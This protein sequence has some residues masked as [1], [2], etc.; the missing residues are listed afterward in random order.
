[1]ATAVER[2]LAQI[3]KA[4]GLRKS[5]PL[6][7]SGERDQ[8]LIKGVV[9]PDINHGGWSFIGQPPSPTFREKSYD[10]L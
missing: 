7:F 10:F 2:R 6:V 8:T 9:I 1:M 5:Q 3:R 4:K